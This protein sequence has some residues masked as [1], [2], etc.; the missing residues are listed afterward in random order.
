[1]PNIEFI[2]DADFVEAGP[3]GEKVERRITKGT[4]LENVKEATAA[5][6]ERRGKAKRQPSRIER[7]MN[8]PVPPAPPFAD[9]AGK[10]ISGRAGD[11]GDTGSKDGRKGDKTPG[12][13][14]APYAPGPG[15]G[16]GPGKT[17]V[18]APPPPPVAPL[19]R[20]DSEGT[21]STGKG[22]KSANKS[23]D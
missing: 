18:A 4:V 14:T 10:A 9:D 17:E 1:M 12:D 20:I 19:P 22:G 13:A 5:R 6:W 3:K 2:E 15:V 8:V 23:T 21:K 7:A 11:T 16:E